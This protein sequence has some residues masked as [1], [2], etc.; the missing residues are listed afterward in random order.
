MS[1]D[2]YEA[3]MESYR[4]FADGAFGQWLQD[5]LSEK[6][7]YYQNKMLQAKSWDEFTEARSNFAAVQ[8][9]HNMVVNP[10]LFF[11]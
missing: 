9:L 1:D 10:Q 8:R 2:K 5:Q 6:V 7:D 4:V 11:N 3:V